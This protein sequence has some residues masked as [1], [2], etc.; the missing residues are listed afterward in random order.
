MN[1]RRITERESNKVVAP[2]LYIRADWHV[3]IRLGAG[4]GR[5]C[6]CWVPGECPLFIRS[7]QLHPLCST[8]VDNRRSWTKFWLM[9]LSFQGFFFPMFVPSLKC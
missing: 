9:V 6:V 2:L 7:P 8:D 5:L 1:K 4:R 3:I